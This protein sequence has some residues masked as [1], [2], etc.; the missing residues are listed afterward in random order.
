MIFK[1]VVAANNELSELKDLRVLF[2]AS[3]V[4][5]TFFY[6]FLFLLNVIQSACM[7]TSCMVYGGR[8]SNVV[9][10]AE[11]KS[12]VQPIFT[13]L[14]LTVDECCYSNARVCNAIDRLACL[15]R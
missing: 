1:F 6:F 3:E 9:T 2:G 11:S 7:S 4:S 8:V 15:P 10:D 12:W 14:L 5:K 13:L